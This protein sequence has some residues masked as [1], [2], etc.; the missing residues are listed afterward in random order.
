VCVCVCARAVEDISSCCPACCSYG[1]LANLI[2]AIY[3]LQRLLVVPLTPYHPFWNIYRGQ[4]HEMFVT[5][6]NKCILKDRCFHWS[7]TKAC[8]LKSIEEN[9]LALTLCTQSCI[10]LYEDVNNCEYAGP[11]DK[12]VRQWIIGSGGTLNSYSA[13]FLGLHNSL[14]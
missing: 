6:Q 14:P 11:C 13:V 7:K 12:W 10:I 8:H 3:P 2:L 5:S 1:R 4:S 9:L